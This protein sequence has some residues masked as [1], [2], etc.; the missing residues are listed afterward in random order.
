MSQQ[1]RYYDRGAQSVGVNPIAWLLGG[2]ISLFAIAGSRVRLH[3]SLVIFA[4]SVLLFGGGSRFMIE[5]RLYAMGVMFMVVLAHE[6]AR[7]FA[8]RWVGGY[9]DEV[10]LWPLGGLA[11]PQAP[12]RPVARLFTVLAGPLAVA[13]FGAAGAVGLYFVN[14]TVVSLHLED[15]FVPS[16]WGASEPAF[17][18]WYI[19]AISYL[20]L[21][22]NA[23]PVPPLDAGHLLQAIMWPFLGYGRALL[24]SCEAGLFT[25][26]VAGIYG[27]ASGYWLL[28]I[29]MFSCALYCVQRR[30]AIKTAGV[31]TFDHYDLQR[32]RR[33]RLSRFAKWRVR[34][35]IR[36]ESNDQLRLDEI[37]GKVHR[38]GIRSLTW[39]ERAV[40]RRA[41]NR[42]RQQAVETSA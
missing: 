16:V 34:R 29:G 39:R 7:A 9:A 33:H 19:Y 6:L 31:E 36:R 5:H 35:Q 4:A 28:S 10:L 24:A 15:V 18:L 23:L 32:P 38:E 20:L 1:D 17:Y 27:I 37:L 25:A 2:S 42:Q 22:V 11:E 21:L 26:A 3:C 8:A 30:S 12:H 40:L 41:T 14:G 13:L